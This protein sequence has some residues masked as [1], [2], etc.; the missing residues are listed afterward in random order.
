MS[1]TTCPKGFYC[2]SNATTCPKPCSP[3]SYSNDTGAIMCKECPA[4][5]KC[6]NATLE[7]EDCP[8]GSW[9]DGGSTTCS[10]CP[11]GYG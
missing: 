3:G 11:P 4:G 5:S 10:L 9:S 1:C 7:P 6:A 2:P 8:D